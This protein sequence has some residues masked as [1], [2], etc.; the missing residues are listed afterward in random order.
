[1]R[2]RTLGNTGVK[3]SEI[4]LG[5]WQLG[6][7]DWGVVGEDQGV[8][9][10]EAS[11]ARGVNFFDT[12]DVYGMGRSERTIG[13][14]L[15]GS[16][17]TVHVATKLG[18]KLW[19]ESGL[20]W[21]ARITL[22]AARQATESSLRNLGLD[23]LF[24]QQ[25]H[26]L[27]SEE[28][29][30]GDVFEHLET[31]K[32]EGWLQHWGCSV[33]TIEEAHLCLAHPGCASLQVIFNVFRQKPIDELLPAATARGVGFLARV[34]LASGLLT[35]RFQPGHRFPPGDHRH[36][37]AD[38]QVFNVGETFAGLPF[39]RGVV[40]AERVRAIAGTD[41]PLA[42][43]ALRWIL[44]FP[45]VTAAIP[46]ASSPAQAAGN[47]DASDLPGLSADVH[48][49]LRELYDAEIAK[50]IRGPY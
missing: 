23:A 50:A 9:V 26:C 5:T 19:V 40:L 18:R 45:G 17:E 28:Y 38:G 44:D 32:R 36:Y 27:P 39:E 41:V 14:F 16:R 34:P 21:P 33:E 4:G 25:W 1:M 11:V 42:S 10:L 20:R 29:R 49:Q 46:G 6:D 7:G 37:N 24:L 3:I 35:G 30:R 47:A 12:A 13:R 15:R 43:W 22:D 48:R 2:Y 31:L 8:R